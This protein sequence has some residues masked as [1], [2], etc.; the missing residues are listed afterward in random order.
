MLTPWDHKS[1][2]QLLEP[3]VITDM[4]SIFNSRRYLEKLSG[5][6]KNPAMVFGNNLVLSQQPHVIIP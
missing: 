2:A 5:T 1:L 3:E 6:L 4:S